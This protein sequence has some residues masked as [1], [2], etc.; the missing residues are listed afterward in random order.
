MA[1]VHAKNSISGLVGKVVYKTLN[2]AQIIQS[3]PK[4]FKQTAATKVSSA[5]FLQCSQWTKT[6]RLGLTPFL[7]GLTDSFMYRRLTGQCYQALLN[8][9]TLPVDQRTFLDTDMS[10]L[11]GFEWNTHSPFAHF[12]TV[13]ITT[14]RNALRQ[15]TVT[16]PEIHPTTDLQ[17]PD[18]TSHAELLVYV[19]ALNFEPNAPTADACW[20]LPIAKNGPTLPPAVW[21]T[22]PLPENYAVV[23]SAKLLYYEANRLTARHYVNSKQLNP[24]RILWMGTT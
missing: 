23:V 3:R 11:A 24:A 12:C 22:P 2:G 16:V 4:K 13:P 5:A 21:T 8:A 7:V 6:L 19:Y 15:V 10:A 18:H 17:F 14:T 1:R 9:T 20:V